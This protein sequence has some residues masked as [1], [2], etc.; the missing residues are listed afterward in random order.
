MCW[1][2]SGQAEEEEALAVQ[3]ARVERLVPAAPRLHSDGIE[4][5]RKSEKQWI[6]KVCFRRFRS[7][8]CLLFFGSRIGLRD[9]RWTNYLQ[10]SEIH[11]ETT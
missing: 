5:G 6:R 2:S 10:H 7:F 8:H 3:K 4:D 9:I 11:Y 1:C